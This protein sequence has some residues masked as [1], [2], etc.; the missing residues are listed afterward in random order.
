M[1]VI[2]VLNIQ[3][4]C[5]RS[6]RLSKCHITRG[7]VQTK[8]RQY[9]SALANRVL[10]FLYLSV[11]MNAKTTNMTFVDIIDLA[12]VLGAGLGAV[13]FAQVDLVTLMNVSEALEY[14]VKMGVLVSTLVYTIYKIRDVRRK[15]EDRALKH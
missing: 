12:K 1:Y 15:E 11:K 4:I 10:K 14:T 8:V 3:Q 13:F 6:P 9:P 7:Y 2:T 5:G